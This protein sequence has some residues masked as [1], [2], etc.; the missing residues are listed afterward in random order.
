MAKRFMSI[1][2]MEEYLKPFV[3]TGDKVKVLDADKLRG[4]PIDRLVYNAVF[5][6]SAEQ[7]GVTRA[8]IKEISA[9]LGA[10]PASIQG[11]YDAMGRGDVSGFTVPAVNIRGMTYD[12]ARALFRAAIKNNSASFL[13]EI[14][15]SEIGYT[16]QQP[17][18]YTS[19]ILAAAIKEVYEGP[20]F[21]QGDHYQMKAE[22]FF[23][24]PEK[25]VSTV[26]ELIKK[27]IS[28]GF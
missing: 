20:V 3:E 8:L 25:E 2:D 17:A 26:K 10:V 23:A 28:A 18:E 24:N 14:A 11:L 1:E 13:I 21:I 4:E 12:V 6:E 19:V 27:S 22:S 7:R 9:Q 16:A 5:H 15:K